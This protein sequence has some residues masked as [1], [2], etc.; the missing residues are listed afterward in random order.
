MPIFEYNCLNCGEQFEHFQRKAEDSASCPLCGQNRL[1][2]LMSLC[3]VG[4]EARS[5]AN[6]SAAHKRAAA[7]RQDRARS[8]HESH[9]NHFGDA[10]HR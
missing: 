7:K 1:R 8:E 2:R 10:P 9:H 4:S 6:L 3:G 5:A